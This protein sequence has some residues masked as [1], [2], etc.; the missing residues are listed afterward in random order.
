MVRKVDYITEGEEEERNKIMEEHIC[1]NLKTFIP[2]LFPLDL[3]GFVKAC[4]V[5]KIPTTCS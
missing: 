2:N 4:L 5:S 3:Q 1:H